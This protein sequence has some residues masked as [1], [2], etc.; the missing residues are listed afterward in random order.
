MTNV[1][2]S[3]PYASNESLPT[4]NCC[5]KILVFPSDPE[6]IASLQRLYRKFA[7]YIDSQPYWAPEMLM[8]SI[9]LI[10]I[11]ED[12]SCRGTACYARIFERLV[13]EYGSRSLDTSLDAAWICASKYIEGKAD[14]DTDGDTEGKLPHRFP[15]S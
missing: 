14:E 3:M 4:C 8:D 1:C 9:A 7:A 2:A 5:E 13:K 12:V 6:R 10:R 11:L 15:R